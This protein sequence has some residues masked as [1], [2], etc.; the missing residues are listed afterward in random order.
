MI[1]SASYSTSTNPISHKDKGC[2]KVGQGG[3][4]ND[5]DDDGSEAAAAAAAAAS[6]PVNV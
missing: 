4:D 2:V 5:D 6:V 1:P 3:E